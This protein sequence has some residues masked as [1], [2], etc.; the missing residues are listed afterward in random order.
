MRIR[1]SCLLSSVY[2]HSSSPRAG[3]VFFPYNRTTHPNFLHDI[4]HPEHPSSASCFSDQP[5]KPPLKKDSSSRQRFPVEEWEEVCAE[6]PSNEG[7]CLSSCGLDGCSE[8]CQL[9]ADPAFIFCEAT[10]ERSSTRH[11]AGHFDSFP[12]R[13]SAADQRPAPDYLLHPLRPSFE[14]QLSMDRRALHHLEIAESSR[15]LEPHYLQQSNH[16]DTGFFSHFS[17]NPPTNDQ[18]SL[19]SQLLYSKESVIHPRIAI[20]QVQL[21]P[22][23]FAANEWDEPRHPQLANSNQRL[24]KHLSIQQNI[25]SQKLFDPRLSAVQTGLS[26]DKRNSFHSPTDQHEITKQTISRISIISEHPKDK[27]RISNCVNE[28]SAYEVMQQNFLD[29]FGADQTPKQNYY[30]KS[31]EQDPPVKGSRIKRKERAPHEV[32]ESSRTMVKKIS[33]S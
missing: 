19:R 33:E 3:F 31:T 26:P 11:P 28:S 10:R 22:T 17:A 6:S 12:A 1:S 5:Q 9:D 30:N 23:Y 29:Q 15:P 32:L 20:P 2:S 14:Y 27:E 13:Q 24:T 7:H 21:G 8:S 16:C 18:V 4:S 25:D